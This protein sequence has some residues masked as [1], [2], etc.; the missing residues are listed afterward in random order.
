MKAVRKV[1]QIFLLALGAVILFAASQLIYP[2]NGAGQA[3]PD[4]FIVLA[5]RGMHTNW[6][7]GE[8]D[9]ATGCEATHIYTPT[10]EL[11]ENTLPSIGAAFDAGATMVE[12]DIRPS[13]DGVIMLNHEEN[14]ECKTDG[15]GKIYDHTVAEL[16]TLDVGYSFTADDGATYPLRGKGVG[17]MPTLTEA[18]AAFPDKAFLLDH[19]DGRRDTAELLVAELKQLPPAQRALIHYW[20]PRAVGDYV[21]GEVPEVTRLL[22]G[23]GEIKQCIM[24][25]LLS[26][27]FAGFGSECRDHG[28]G[29]TRD[30]SRF[31]WGFPHRFIRQAHANGSLVFLMVDNAQDVEWARDIPVDGI[32]TDYIEIVGPAGW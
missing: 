21:R 17:A 19:K 6:R 29:M 11:I 32:I 22:A 31:I 25:Y 5:H 27:G 15:T 16:K 2:G 20:G 10:H 24:P 12:V 30:V 18:L 7:R 3:R 1:L 28:V 8:Y 26:F 4:E 23:R 9:I 14:L 13:A